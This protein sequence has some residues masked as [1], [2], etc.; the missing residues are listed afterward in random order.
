MIDNAT[1]YI[2][3]FS[4]SRNKVPEWREYFPKP[5]EGKKPLPEYYHYFKRIV[6]SRKNRA[7]LFLQLRYDA[8]KDVFRLRI[9]GS[10]RKW[11]FGGNTRNDLT[12]LQFIDCIKLLSIKIGISL[13]DLL[14]AKVTKLESGV[15]L[16]LDKKFMGLNDCFVRF[17]SFHK[18]YEDST[19]YLRGTNYS[20]VSYEKLLE[21]NKKDLSIKGNRTKTN[22]LKKYNH[23][24]FEIKVNKVSGVTFYKKNASTLKELMYNWNVMILQLHLYVNNIDFVDFISPDRIIDFPN[25]SNLDKK[26]YLK[27][28]EIQKNG[29]YEELRKIED[30]PSTNKSRN[31]KSFF[32]DYRRYITNDM[33]DLKS[34]FLL[35]LKKKTNRLV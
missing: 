27:F 10:L 5:K 18:I 6:Y 2:E 19:L 9:N 16:L 1:Y 34:E 26:K 20:I 21:I 31:I 4:T 17:G 22:V 33:I 23:F 13:Q 30:Q 24:R 35:E 25:L 32:R 8:N 15:T 14:K 7:F 11:Y 29:F 12:K 3:D 28:K